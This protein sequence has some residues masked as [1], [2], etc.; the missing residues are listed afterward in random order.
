MTGHTADRCWQKGGGMENGKDPARSRPRANVAIE[1]EENAT[2][3]TIVEESDERDVTATFD[4]NEL[5]I[6]A[7]GSLCSESSAPSLS[8]SSSNPSSPYAAF[9]EG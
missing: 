8:P 7:Y 3:L 1:V 5:L 4:D 6:D 2:P 9:I